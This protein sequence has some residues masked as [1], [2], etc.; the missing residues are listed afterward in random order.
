VIQ[1]LDARLS[2]WVGSVL[3]DKVAVSF[4][5]PGPLK[6]GATSPAVGMYLFEIAPATSDGLD[7]SRVRQVLVRYLVTA[8]ASRPEEEHEL[9]GTLLAAAVNQGM[10]LDLT[11]LSGQTWAALGLAPRPAFVLDEL[12]VI[13]RPVE[14][15]PVVRQPPIVR[16]VGTTVLEGRVMGPLQRPLGRAEVAHLGIGRSATTDANGWFRFPL[17]PGGETPLHRLEV[18][19][20]GVKRL[21]TVDARAGAAINLQFDYTEG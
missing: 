14:K 17:A 5:P 11:P 3:P 13:E 20:K 12:L 21:F 1:A 19:S 4:G 8:W 6:D 2:E 15:V 16:S 7:R 10:K 18:Q 9:L